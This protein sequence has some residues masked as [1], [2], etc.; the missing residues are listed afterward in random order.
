MDETAAGANGLR[1]LP[2]PNPN[3]VVLC[4]IV[5]EADGILK[6]PLPNRDE[7]GVAADDVNAKLFGIVKVLI[8]EDAGNELVLVA[9]AGVGVIVEELNKFEEVA[10]FVVIDGAEVLGIDVN[11]GD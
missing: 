2:A 5:V 10:V 7:A 4:T 11:P 6:P 8:V 3:G 9:I 1:G